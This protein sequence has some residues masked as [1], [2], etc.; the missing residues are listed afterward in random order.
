[1]YIIYQNTDSLE[2]HLLKEDDERND[3]YCFVCKEVG[4]ID[5]ADVIALN[6]LSSDR[7]S[8]MI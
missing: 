5:E 4:R 8:T 3:I 7:I 1:M 2:Y 6:I